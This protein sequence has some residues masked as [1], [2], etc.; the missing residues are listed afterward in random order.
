MIAQRFRQSRNGIETGCG[1]LDI[2]ID[3]IGLNAA[4]PQI[5]R[6]AKHRSGQCDFVRGG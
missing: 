4:G 5:M 6:V 1:Q 3:G 2:V